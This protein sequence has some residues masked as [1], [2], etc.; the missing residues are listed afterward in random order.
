MNDEN[1]ISSSSALKQL[2]FRFNMDSEDS[3]DS[4]VKQTKLMGKISNILENGFINCELR[5]K[6]IMEFKKEL[7]IQDFYRNFNKSKLEI[8]DINME[9]KNTNKH[10]YELNS[11][12]LKISNEIIKLRQGIFR[13][14]NIIILVLILIL[15]IIIFKL[16]MVVLG[17]INS[18]DIL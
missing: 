2:T 10:I 4:M 1:V 8:N 7:N 5:L 11:N 9:L 15:T 12:I 14:A 13:N 6:Q 16:I 17:V 18:V 3:K